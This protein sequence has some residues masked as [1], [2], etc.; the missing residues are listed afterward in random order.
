MLPIWIC[1]WTLSNSTS[2]CLTWGRKK[3]EER[4]KISL[5]LTLN[6]FSK[7][8]WSPWMPQEKGYG[9]CFSPFLWFCKDREQVRAAI[10]TVAQPSSQVLREL[11]GSNQPLSLW[12]CIAIQAWVRGSTRPL[13]LPEHV[14]QITLGPA[15]AR[16]FFTKQLP[17]VLNKCTTFHTAQLSN[18]SR[19]YPSQGSTWPNSSLLQVSPSTPIPLMPASIVPVD[20]YRLCVSPTSS[21]FPPGLPASRSFLVPGCP[22]GSG[23]GG[24]W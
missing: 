10:Y 8:C 18:Q 12:T 13:S 17:T 19:D 14:A 2:Y 7:F 9:L 23:R 5:L 16:E 6:P 4:K 21:L 1:L 24:S 22:P 15:S 3:R 11:S 20:I